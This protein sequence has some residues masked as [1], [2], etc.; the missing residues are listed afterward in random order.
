[1]PA[2][3][4]YLAHKSRKDRNGEAP[5]YLRITCSRKK[6]YFNTGERI[7]PDYLRDNPRVGYWI[8]KSHSQHNRLNKDVLE[9]IF[10]EAKRIATELRQN[11]RESA[12]AIKQR[13]QGASKE[14]FFT[15]A[16]E[17]LDQLEKADQFYL[18]K[19]TNATLS[20]LK[21]YLASQSHDT[22]ALK[23]TEVTPGLIEG[24]QDWMQHEKGNKGSTIRKNMSD[25]R[26]ILERA[27]KQNLIFNDPFE[28][29]EPVNQ[30]DPAPKVKLT[31][32][33]IKKLRNVSLPTGSMDDHVRNTFIL[34]FY[35]YGTRAGDMIKMRWDRI[36]GGRIS[37]RMSK[38][39]SVSYFKIPAPAMDI[40]SQYRS[41]PAANGV[42][43]PFL[44][45]LTPRE[46]NDKQVVENAVSSALTVVNGKIKEVAKQ[47]G[48]NE[49][50]AD[51]ISSHVARH[52]LATYLVN[53]EFSIYDIS[54]RL[55]HKSVTTT[56]HYLNRL[57]LQAKDQAIE[58]TFE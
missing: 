2:T 57:G 45:D 23:F 13:L 58:T 25:V 29:V 42:M 41:E 22:D 33:Q 26:R 31:Y 38:T 49:E 24:L 18:R 28:D 15:I 32:K 5:I 21:G 56:E 46:L 3:F 40:L 12:D 35:L 4:R 8:K 47:A 43:L 52:S 50:M 17:E 27:E 10:H 44:A 20:K 7:D 53:K 19:Q 11:R 9:P 6:K 51:N 37:Y 1:M 14:N 48:I 16:A 30:S 36:S 54:K 39:K 55:R 34:Q